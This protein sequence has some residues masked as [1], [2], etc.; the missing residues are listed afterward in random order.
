MK[1]LTL[2]SVALFAGAAFSAPQSSRI[3]GGTQTSIEKFPSIVGVEFFGIITRTWSQSCAANILTTRYVLSAAHCFRGLLYRPSY[4][5][6]RAGTSYRNTGGIVSYVETEFNHP[7]YGLNGADGDISVIRLITP[8]VYSPVVQQATIVA[9]GYKIPDNLPVVH[10]GWGRIE[11]GGALSPVLLETTIFTINNELCAARY[12]TLP[13]PGIVT[14]NMICAG[15][16]DVGGKD[17][18]QGDSGGP[19]YFSDIL[20]GVVSWGHECANATYP[21]VST[22]V[23][24]Y[25][26]WIAAAVS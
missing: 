9:Q 19:L 20:V 18:C 6:I 25:T 8:L 12:L 23:S 5:R 24:S 10:A 26:D 7:S 21:G 22:A 2:L 16:L 14:E 15:I 13:R 4:R 11:Y 17:A 1:V 3:V